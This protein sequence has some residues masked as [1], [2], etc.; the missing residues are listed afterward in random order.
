MVYVNKVVAVVRC[1]NKFLREQKGCVFLPFG[2]EYSI[3]IKNL[4]SRKCLVKISI[5][6]TDIL[7]GKR[8][9]IDPNSEIEIER[10][11]ENLNEGKRLR[12]IQKTKEISEYRGDKVDDGFIRIE[13]QFEK[14]KPITVTR[15]VQ[16][17][18]YNTY[19]PP[20]WTFTSFNSGQTFGS[21]SCYYSNNI[22]SAIGSSDSRGMSSSS[23]TCN[24]S[25]RIDSFQNIPDEGITVKGS[26]SFQT[27]REVTV[28]ELEENTHTII[29]RLKGIQS[30]GQEIQKIISVRDKIICSICGKKNRSSFK[31]CTHCSAA[32]T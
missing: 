2:S 14:E 26:D 19:D 8:L 12:F 30:G 29:L 11:L 23:N 1:N 24:L 7:Y 27:F 15:F 20:R 13:F 31:F 28:N 6:G 32:L 16:E 4:E 25:S 10:F 3:Q 18:H 9:V 22:G 21:Q 5:D 17:H